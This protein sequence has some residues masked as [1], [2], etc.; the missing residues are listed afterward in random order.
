VA[1]GAV[2][3]AVVSEETCRILDWRLLRGRGVAVVLGDCRE[4]ERAGVRTVAS[5][6]HVEAFRL[7][8]AGL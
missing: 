4:P 8:G 1:A 5:R 7:V 6:S 2:V 3:L